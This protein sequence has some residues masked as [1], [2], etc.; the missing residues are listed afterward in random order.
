MYGTTNNL[1]EAVQA[2]NAVQRRSAD[3][4]NK[5]LQEITKLINETIEQLKYSCETTLEL[6]PPVKR[7]L[8]SAG[9]KVIEEQHKTIIDWSQP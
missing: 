9:Y 3:N 4:N 8:I 7:Q 6:L 1:L 5:Q 2:Y